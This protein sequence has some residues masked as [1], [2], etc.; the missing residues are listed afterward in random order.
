MGVPGDECLSPRRRPPRCTTS[1]SFAR[2]SST[3]SSLPSTVEEKPHCGDR[4]SCSSG[5]NFA[6]SSMRRLSS[7]ASSSS[8]RL[9]G[10]EPEH[11][12]LARRHEPQRLEPAGALVVELAE[13]A[14]DVQPAEEGLGHELVAALGRP[15]GAEVAAAHVRGDAH[16]RRAGRE[17]GVD[18][19]RCSARA[20][21]SGSSPRAATC[22]ALRRIV[23]VGQ[24]GVVELQ[25]AAAEL[26]ERG[27]LGGVGGRQVGEELLEIGVDGAVDGRRAAAEV[28]HARRRDRQLRRRP[29]R[30]APARNRTRRRRSAPP[31]LTRSSIAIPAG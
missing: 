23:Q 28:D 27:D 1:S 11:H 24:P 29:W 25:V 6:A 16:A 21:E 20:G 5:T 26:G 18:L 2:C 8:P 13:E 3:V 7:S 31:R 30:R 17:R 22:G 10:D 12:L 9:R 15:G 4:H 14:V 19:P